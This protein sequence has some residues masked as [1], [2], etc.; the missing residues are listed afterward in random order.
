[1]H[2]FWWCVYSSLL[3]ISSLNRFLTVEFRDFF[4]YSGLKFFSG[5]TIIYKYSS[6]SVAS[7]FNFLRVSIVHRAL[8]LLMKSGVSFFFLLCIVFSVSKYS[9]PNS[10]SQR[11]VL[12]SSSS[13]SSPPLFL[14]PLLSFFFFN[15]HPRI[16]FFKLIF[17][18]DTLIDCLPYTPQPEIKLET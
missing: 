10:R 2:L 17:E 11:F 16:C 9:L 6:Q 8:L 3:S 4:I 13:S 5:N 12:F 7:L 1:M 18:R 14:L 15:P